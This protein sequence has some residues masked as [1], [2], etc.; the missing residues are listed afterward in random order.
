LKN[1]HLPGAYTSPVA[2]VGRFG[3]PARVL[4][5]RRPRDPFFNFFNFSFDPTTTGKNNA[6]GV[7]WTLEIG[8]T[9][10]NNLGIFGFV[11]SVAS[12]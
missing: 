4:I 9:A 7:R 2:G 5:I 11:A 6:R 8:R 12:A 1:D 3:S 10:A